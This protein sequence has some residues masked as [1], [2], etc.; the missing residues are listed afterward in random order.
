MKKG[1]LRIAFSLLALS[2]ST[3]NEVETPKEAENNSLIGKWKL[4]E[5]YSDPGD[6]S[7]TFQAANSQKTFEFFSND[8]VYSNGEI[9][10]LSTDAQSPSSSTFSD[11]TKTINCP[12]SYRLFYEFKNQHLMLYFPCIEPCI[13]KLERI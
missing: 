12:N 8:S 3:S 13:F 10:S 6:G 7:G 4:I 2:C 5:T 1:L 11:S 9:C